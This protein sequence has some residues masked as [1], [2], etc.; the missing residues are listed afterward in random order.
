MSE[1]VNHGLVARYR[2]RFGGGAPPPPEPEPLPEP[3]ELPGFVGAWHFST[4]L[5]LSG[6]NVDAWGS[7]AA[8][9]GPV[10]LTAG[11][12]KPTLIDGAPSF[13][14]TTSPMDAPVGAFTAATVAVA[15]RRSTGSTARA[16]LAAV[17]DLTISNG[18]TRVEFPAGPVASTLPN[19]WREDPYLG[20]GY[21]PGPGAGSPPGR[22]IV[23]S[24]ENPRA[25]AWQ[26]STGAPVAAGA[27]GAY[28]YAAGASS[29][30][31]LSDSAFP[32]H[33]EVLAVAAWKHPATQAECETILA[34]LD[35][36]PVPS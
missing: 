23:A 32:W 25:Y 35:S 14:A 17:R 11:G 6:G 20:G 28:G 19:I 21:S 34:W 31:R 1:A 15:Y 2:R 16:F 24:G 36:L 10:V 4:G 18:I 5:E 26:P 3:P 30:L 7:F 22:A 12:T 8:P 9:G 29:I 27:A 33:G 13:G